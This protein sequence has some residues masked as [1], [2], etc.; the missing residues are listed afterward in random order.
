MPSTLRSLAVVGL[1]AAGW[2]TLSFGCIA[3]PDGDEG[4][5]EA[6]CADLLVQEAC[7][8]CLESACC[9][10]VR[11]CIADTAAG[12]CAAC[13]QGDGDACA[14]GETAES[15]VSCLLSECS[16][17]CAGGAP[18]PQCDAPAQRSSGGACAP[19]GE[20]VACNPLTN[21]ECEG[22]AGEVCD[23]DTGGFRCFPGPNEQSVCEPC[24]GDAGFCGPG[25]TCFQSVTAGLDGLVIAGS[26]ARTC[27]DDSDCGAGV[28]ASIVRAGEARVGVCLEDGGS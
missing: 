11:G 25:L 2:V 20:G 24:G 3:D 13:I 10:E 14:T 12:G 26:C 15:L 27:C 17:A 19:I 22:D 21:A 7:F 28:C 23:F 6:V 9:A 8:D 4:E 1:L 18:G 16:V 5:G